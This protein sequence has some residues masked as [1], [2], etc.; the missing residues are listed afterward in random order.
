[1]IVNVLVVGPCK[2]EYVT[3]YV[4]FFR[5]GFEKLSTLMPLES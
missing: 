5:A 1:M 2:M 3:V 4:V